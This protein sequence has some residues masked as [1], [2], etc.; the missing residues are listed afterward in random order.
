[1]ETLPPA[2]L[3]G[4]TMLISMVVGGV[5]WLGFLLYVKR[6]FHGPESSAVR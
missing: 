3:E 2:L 4:P 1:L 5:V 6:Y